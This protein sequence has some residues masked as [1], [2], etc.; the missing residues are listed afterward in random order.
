[1]KY[2]LTNSKRFLIVCLFSLLVYNAK[3]QKFSLGPQLGANISRIDGSGFQNGYKLSY[4]AGGFFSVNLS[5]KWIL[6]TEILW[7]QIKSDTASGFRSIYSNL[8]NQN[9]N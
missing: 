1:M 8:Q 3:S 4:H 5:K 7:S 6:Q 9:L 2:N